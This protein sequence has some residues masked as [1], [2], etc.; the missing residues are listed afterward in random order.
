MLRSSILAV[1]AATGCAAAPAAASDTLPRSL[2][3]VTPAVFASRADIADDPREPGIVVSTRRGYMRDRSLQGASAD[4]VHLRAVIDRGTGKVTWQVWHELAYTWGQKDLFAVHYSSGGT[5]RQ[6]R[7]F[8]V[9]H[10]PDRCPAVDAVGFCGL[11]TRVGFELPENTVREIAGSYVPGSRASWRLRF[12]DA[13][14][15]D[16]TG[17]LAPAEAAGLLQV[18]EGLQRQR[19]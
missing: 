11:A 3:V 12:Q 10:R 18:V 17:G 16:V 19:G 5:E 4:D 7:P 14:G 15:R 8:Q 1:L 6:V 2:A 9:E 13:G